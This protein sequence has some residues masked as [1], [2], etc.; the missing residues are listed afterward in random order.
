[1]TVGITDI[2]FVMFAGLII[3]VMFPKIKV[4]WAAAKED[5]QRRKRSKVEVEKIT[6]KI[7][8]SLE[9][10]QSLIIEVVRALRHPAPE[11]VQPRIKSQLDEREV[12]LAQLQAMRGKSKR[13]MQK[14]LDQVMQQLQ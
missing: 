5:D 12:L 11:Q 8:Q 1:M 14:E 2:V 9:R 4:W 10:H 7:D 13:E 3:Y 6:E